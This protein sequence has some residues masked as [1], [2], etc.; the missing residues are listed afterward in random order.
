MANTYNRQ[1][2]GWAR[3]SEL[4]EEPSLW[5]RK[6][7]SPT[8][9]NQGQLGDCWFLASAA[10]IAENPKRIEKIFTNH[11]YS[12]EGVFETNFY[13]MGKPAAMII[14]DRL[15]INEGMDRRYTNCCVKRTVNARPSVNGAWWVPLLEKAYSKFNQ[16]YSNMDG[17]QP[18]QALRE[19]TGM[20]I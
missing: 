15:P 4:E 11:E 1:V 2:T 16:S 17:G 3:P 10:A 12:A 6:G 8:G 20:P 14:D 9:V 18:E 5:G 13:H 19:L 7:I